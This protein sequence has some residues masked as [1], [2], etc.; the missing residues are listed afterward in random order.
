LR[1]QVAH[2]V[3]Q[4]VVDLLEAVEVEKSR[5]APC[6]CTAGSASGSARRLARAVSGSRSARERE[7]AVARSRVHQ[8][9]PGEKH[10]A[11]RG[12]LDHPDL[13]DGERQSRADRGVDEDAR[14][15]VSR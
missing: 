10:H 9:A 6:G 2:V 14:N 13:L 8:Q 5:S 12:V 1:A 7:P 3:A 15:Q 4:A 11:H